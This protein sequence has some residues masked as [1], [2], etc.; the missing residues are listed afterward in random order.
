[1]CEFMLGKKMFKLG[2][3]MCEFKLGTFPFLAYTGELSVP[4][5]YARRVSMQGRLN[6]IG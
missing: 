6:R 3:K 5:A 4:Y 2:K 1:M